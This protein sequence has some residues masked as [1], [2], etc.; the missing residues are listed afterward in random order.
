VPA[1]AVLPPLDSVPH[2]TLSLATQGDVEQAGKLI[3]RAGFL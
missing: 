2:S 1:N 3:G